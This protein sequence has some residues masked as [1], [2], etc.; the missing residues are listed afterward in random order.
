MSVLSLETLLCKNPLDFVT[1][2]HNSPLDLME[3]L[4]ESGC[5]RTQYISSV[6]RTLDLS[7]R[8]II[9]CPFLARLSLLCLL[10][11]KLLQ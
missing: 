7:P 3:M 8:L 1:W 5:H 4:A 2:S 9:G 6:G 11:R 10:F